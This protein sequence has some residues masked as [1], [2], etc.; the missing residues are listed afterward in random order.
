MQKFEGEIR[1]IFFD[2]G[3]TLVYP[4]TG[5]WL[6]APRAKELLTAALGDVAA[7]WETLERHWKDI[8]DENHLWLS[9]AQEWQAYHELYARTSASLGLSWD[10]AT[11]R[12]VTDEQVFCD[13]DY[14]KVYD[15][16]HDL[17][18]RLAA[19]YHIGVISDTAP[20]IGRRLHVLGLMPYFSS[21]TGSY[22]LNAR[23]PDPLLFRHA[24][25]ASG[26]RGETCVFVDDLAKN[27]DAAAKFGIQGAQICT[28][29]HV[30]PSETHRKL[31]DIREIETL[32]P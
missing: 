16:V 3:W 6:Y 27:L 24:L 19:R 22:F 18:A 11:L 9:E 13:G 7:A 2:L 1:G 5:H 17:L 28:G 26:L 30:V 20:A 4:S 14:Y 25:L 15:G 31:F 12:A 21:F 8:Q 29:P 10:A 23:K 32:L